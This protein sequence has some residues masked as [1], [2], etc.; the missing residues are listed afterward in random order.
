MNLIELEKSIRQWGVDRNI[1]AEGGAT[2]QMQI[3]KCLEEV[4]EAVSTLGKMHQIEDRSQD[5]LFEIEF[6]S[7]DYKSSYNEY[8]Q[9]NEVNYPKLTSQLKDDLGDIVV[10]IIQAARLADTDLTECLQQSYDEIKDRKGTMQGGKF[11]KE[12]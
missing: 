12:T 7:D 4:A 9:I 2:V 10:C 6:G 3:S 8:E 11:I 1:T 5:L